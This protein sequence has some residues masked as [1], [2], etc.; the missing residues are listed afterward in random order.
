MKI[1]NLIKKSI[2]LIGMFVLFFLGVDEV[3]ALTIS[4]ARIEVNG[5]PGTVIKK[6]ITLFNDNQNAEETYYVSYSNFEAQG[7]SGSPMFVE[8]KNGLGTWMDA[9]ESV[10][11]A[12]GES[13]NIPLI[14][15]IPADAYA[16]GY[17][18]VVFF[19]NNSNNGNGG[20]VSVG[21]KTGTLI[22]L[23]ING[24]VLEAGGLVGFNTLKNKKFYNSLPVS[25]QYR[26]KNDGND[27]VKPQ[28]TITLRNIFYF[29][30]GRLDAN[31]VSGNVLPNSTRLFNIDW[32][33][34]SRDKNY[35]PPTSFVPAFFD[36]AS[37]QWKNFA[38]GPYLAKLNLSYG[39]QNLQASK[40]IFFFVFPW[41]L[42]ICLAVVFV[43]VF[44]VGGKLLKRYNQYIIKKARASMMSTKDDAKI[45]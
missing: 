31:A 13:K 19:G 3:S 6:E 37:Y 16:G 18:A 17:F 15:T 9:G 1:S 38:I 34:Y 42:I 40:T 11:I 26:F 24:D 30:S 23:S 27:R 36:Q 32:I 12:P 21:A 45:I 5:D 33:K 43:I 41:Q 4:P 25:F 28:G 22:L 14:I 20:Q 7:E 29:R 8:P 10:T 35:I 2:V 44:W 39:M